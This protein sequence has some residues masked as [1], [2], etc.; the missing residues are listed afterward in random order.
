MNRLFRN[1]ES[2]RLLLGLGATNFVASSIQRNNISFAAKKGWSTRAPYSG[3]GDLQLAKD[4][5]QLQH[6][7]LGCPG[8]MTTTGTSVQCHGR[9]GILGEQAMQL[10][11]NANAANRPHV[12]RLKAGIILPASVKPGAP[13]KSIPCAD[14]AA[15]YL[16]ERPD[17]PQVQVYRGDTGATGA[18][19][20]SGAKG[21]DG[22]M[23]SPAPSTS[24]P[25]RWLTIAALIGVGAYAFWP[26]I[27]NMMGKKKSPLT[28]K[29]RSK[30][31]KITRTTTLKIPKAAR[32]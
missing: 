1:P 16:S 15:Q 14:I 25:W 9:D 7:D 10:I 28:K 29:R 17:C 26:E 30:D 2:T 12:Q 18:K 31:L 24:G 19:G 27:Q 23:G 21:T 3:P 8:S 20:D 22:K 13:V 5:W 4:V 11:A 6:E 32:M